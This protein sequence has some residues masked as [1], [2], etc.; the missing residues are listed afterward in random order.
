MVLATM[1]C[2]ILVQ[3]VQ[4]MREPNFIELL[5]HSNEVAAVAFVAAPGLVDGWLIVADAAEQGVAVWDD[6]LKLRDFLSV[7][8]SPTVSL[9]TASP[10]IVAAA[11]GGV[12]KIFDLESGSPSVSLVHTDA[13]ACVELPGPQIAAGLC[14]GDLGRHCLT[15]WDLRAPQRHACCIPAPARRPTSL[16]VPVGGGVLDASRLASG[17]ALLATAIGS[18]FEAWDLRCTLRPLCSC[19]TLPGVGVANAFSTVSVALDPTGELVALGFVGP[20]PSEGVLLV[21][22]IF[23]LKFER[24]PD[25]HT[26]AYAL[27]WAEPFSDPIVSVNSLLGTLIV[28]DGSSLR[29]FVVDQS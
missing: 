19:H 20:N 6:R 8:N 5:D 12:V 7:D 4:Q 3:E 18:S 28:G 9:A 15:L 17:G 21:G 26:P 27:E 23:D 11:A 29:G 10:G 22:N 1:D 16:G 14:A 24:C 25:V 2:S 13:F